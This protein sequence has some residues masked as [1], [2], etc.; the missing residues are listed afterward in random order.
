[1]LCLP[2]YVQLV[3]GAKPEP[4]ELPGQLMEAL[5]SRAANGSSGVTVARLDIS[6]LETSVEFYFANGLSTSSQKTYKAGKEHYLDFCQCYTI[7]PLPVSESVLCKFTSF[8]VDQG[9]KHRTLKTY[10][11]DREIF[12]VTIFS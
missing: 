1:M 7:V 10:T 3:A 11:V 5:V 8:L 9:L 2:F 4:T 12:V 6:K